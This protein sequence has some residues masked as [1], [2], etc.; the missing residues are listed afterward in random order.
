MSRAETVI[1]AL[2]AA[3]QAEAKGDLARAA[4]LLAQ[5]ELG[6]LSVRA[7]DAYTRVL[8]EPTSRIRA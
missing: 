1:A 6:L 5:A 2:A 8:Y 7:V 4:E 3:D